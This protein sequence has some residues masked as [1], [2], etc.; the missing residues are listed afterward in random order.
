M[1][2]KLTLSAVA[3][4]ACFG[5]AYAGGA[6]Q[7]YP[8]VGGNGATNC[9]SFG[10]NGV[11][12]QFQPAGPSAI[13]GN[14]TIPADTNVQGAGSVGNPA[15]VSI[16]LASLGLGNYV[17]EAPLTGVSITIAATTRTLIIEPAGTIA[18]HTVVLPAST[19][20]VDGQ[21][22]GLCS[23]QI[24]T[25]LTITPGSGTT[26]SNTQ[27]ATIVPLGTGA[28]ACPEWIYRQAN[29]TWYRTH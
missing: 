20:L 4:L 13:T 2:K 21:A 5:I 28:A 10:N 23:T 15:T 14:E 1:F 22:F 16:P 6:F 25:A 8:A 3:L 29:T 19:A 26:V 9:L 17:Y 18:T 27:T 12:N 11:C 24:I 7:G